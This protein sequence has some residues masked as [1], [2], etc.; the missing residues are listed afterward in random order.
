MCRLPFDFKIFGNGSASGGGSGGQAP[1]TA[2]NRIICLTRQT[3]EVWRVDARAG[4]GSRGASGAGEEVGSGAHGVA[5]TEALEARCDLVSYVHATLGVA[6]VCL[7]DLALTRVFPSGGVSAEDDPSHGENLEVLVLAVDMDEARQRSSRFSL[8]L[9][10]V[11]AD[12]GWGRNHVTVKVS[13]DCFSPEVDLAR[14]GD[15]DPH[16]PGGSGDG[17]MG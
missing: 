5:G 8:H 13:S 1:I 9:V 12:D 10:R 4:K 3:L 6:K 14:S 15:S 11:S 2:S 17:W 7:L 16:A